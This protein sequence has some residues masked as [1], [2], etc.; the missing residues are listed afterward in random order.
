DWPSTLVQLTFGENFNQPLHEEEVICPGLL[1]GKK[2]GFRMFR[3]AESNRYP[4]WRPRLEPSG[5]NEP[6]HRVAWPASLQRLTFGVPFDQPLESIA[7]WPPQLQH[8]TFGC[9]FNQPIVGVLL[10]PSLVS[11]TFGPHF[12]QPID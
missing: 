8:L 11:L 9:F 1:G 4:D 10:P 6:I 5:F 12:N 3:C 7:A 2:I